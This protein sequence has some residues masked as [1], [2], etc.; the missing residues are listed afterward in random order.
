VLE[1]D[2]GSAGWPADVIDVTGGIGAPRTTSGCAAA[3][4]KA[5]MA[6]EEAQKL[7]VGVIW[8]VQDVGQATVALLPQNL[9]VTSTQNPSMAAC[10]QNVL[11]QSALLKI[12]H[13]NR[14]G[15][16]MVA[17][18]SYRC[19]LHSNGKG[20]LFPCQLV[21]CVALKRPEALK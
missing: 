15:L 3:I 14:G 7:Q 17:P 19:W 11:L 10:V 16:T 6:E 12:C 13:A 2:L 21:C 18:L 4:L 8:W 1:A 9:H 5:E 20:G